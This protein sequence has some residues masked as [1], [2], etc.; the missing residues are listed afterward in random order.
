MGKQQNT[1]DDESI[2][3]HSAFCAATELELADNADV[4]EF[5]REYIL[6][7]EPIKIDMLVVRV[8]DNVILKNEIA[9]DFFRGHNVIEYKSPGDEVN[10]DTLYKVIAYAALYKAETGGYV[11]AVKDN[12][13]TMSIVREGKPVKLLDMLRKRNFQIDT[14]C[15]GI[16]EVGGLIF[17]YK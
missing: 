7:K 1:E 10:I 15:K 5:H 9:K 6:G 17:P 12:D 11:D 3:W 13:I 14:R 4:L 16:Y 8:K 2:R